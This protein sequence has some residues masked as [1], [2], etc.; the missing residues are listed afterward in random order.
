M[1]KIVLLRGALGLAA[2]I[3]V[4][5][6]LALGAAR[7]AGVGGSKKQA[8]LARLDF[9]PEVA[10]SRLPGPQ[11]EAA[12]AV[13]PSDGRV[14]LAGSNDVRARRMAVYNSTDGGLRWQ[15]AHLPLPT[16]AHVCATSD[17]SVAIDGR[18]NQY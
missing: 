8:P 17:P 10:I 2:I 9:A 14:L 7:L 3:A 13:D 18:G 11:S 4:P 5:A 6:L 12:V 16:G 1:R 15:T